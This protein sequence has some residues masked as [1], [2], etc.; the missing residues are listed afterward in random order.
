[1][2]Q[3]R[4]MMGMP[5]TLEVIDASITEAMFDTVFDY[6]EYI[7]EKFSTYKDTSEISRINRQELT[8]EES[9]EDMQTIFAL[10]EQTRLE[11]NGYF[12]IQHKGSYDP[13]G[14]VKG[15]AIFHAAEILR[16]HGF[17]NY[18]VDAGGDIQ[19]AGCN[20]VG[21]DWRVGIRNP[22]NQEE[23]VKVL[24]VTNCG[25]ATSGTYVRGQ[26]IYNPLDADQLITDILSLTV[27][28]PDIYEADRFATAAFAMGT[29]GINF[30]E[31]LEGFDGYMI[32][33]NKQATFTTGFEKWVLHD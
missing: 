14:V 31:S 6:F 5:I 4:L 10:S 23:I 16:Q 19:M 2:K 17:E 29:G 25:V 21:Q 32:D 22:F 11:T 8:W 28:G 26:H 3:T 15:W 30:I 20:S 1:M 33:K 12:N 9:S 7:D 27:I 24:S 13:S 18:Y